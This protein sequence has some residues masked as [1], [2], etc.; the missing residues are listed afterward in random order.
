LKSFSPVLATLAS[1]RRKAQSILPR[2]V[3]EGNGER[4]RAEAERFSVPITRVPAL[5]PTLRCRPAE[6]MRNF[7][8]QLF[9]IIRLN[10]GVNGI[11]PPLARLS[12]TL[13]EKGWS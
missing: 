1:S 9:G 13:R 4:F 7:I 11:V 6:A 10:Y 3:Y 12:K 5:A 8:S 2:L